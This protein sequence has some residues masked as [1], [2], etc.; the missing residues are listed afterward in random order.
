MNSGTN[1][2]LLDEIDLFIFTFILHFQ[3]AYV[4]AGWTVKSLFCPLANLN[5]LHLLPLCMRCIGV[6]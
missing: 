6:L 3:A 4:P 5:L 2:F 1:S